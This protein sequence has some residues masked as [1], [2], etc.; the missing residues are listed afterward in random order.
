MRRSEWRR[1]LETTTLRVAVGAL[2]AKQVA[3]TAAS[4]NEAEFRAFS[5]F[6]E[7][8]VIEYLIRRGDIFPETFVEI[9]VED[10]GEANTR[11]LVEHRQW[12]GAIVD[13]NPN[14]ARDL[15]R[16]QLD[17]RA[18]VRATS[19]FVTRENARQIVEP[20]LD[21]SD[22]G[23]L[24]IDIDGVDYWVLKELIEFRPALVI[25][26]YN[27]LFGP[28]ATV[29]VPYAQDFDR[30]DPRF[31]NIYYGASLGAFAH[32][33]VEANDY[34]LVA[35]TEAGNNAFFVRADRLGRVPAKTLEEAF[36]PRRFAEHRTSAGA[37]S[38]IHSPR[39]QLEDVAWLPLI[40][41]RSGAAVTVGGLLPLLGDR[42]DDS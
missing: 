9:G 23:I 12:R 42:P 39:F 16:T 40:D 29:T 19:T 8:G 5:Q 32:L 34:A 11:F 31:H 24:S 6:G 17:W 37:L 15:S 28:L 33:L 10:Y 22:L 20:L 13:L 35:C 18:Q 41:V 14:L 27:S 1:Q 30:R 38:G 4:A 26:E 3:G 2:A 21:G 7:D 25:V 36:R